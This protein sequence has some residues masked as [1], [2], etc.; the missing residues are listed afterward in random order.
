MRQGSCVW[1]A[2]KDNTRHREGTQG[3]HWTYY[4]SWL[5]AQDDSVPTQ[6]TK[7]SP[8]SHQTVTKQ[9]PNSHQTV[10]KNSHQTVTKPQV[11]HLS[12]RPSVCACVTA[13]THTHTLSLSHTHTHT[14]GLSLSLSLSLSSP[15]G[16]QSRTSQKKVDCSFDF[17]FVYCRKSQPDTDGERGL[18]GATGV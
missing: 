9:S 8:N 16:V 5:V 14:Q 4:W 6:V 2:N 10:T 18:T 7:Q 13:H 1:T 15:G 17:F 12:V 11:P 3:Q